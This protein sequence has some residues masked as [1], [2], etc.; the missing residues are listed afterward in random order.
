M[1]FYLLFPCVIHYTHIPRIIS[2][3]IFRYHAKTL[4]LLGLNCAVVLGIR[5]LGDHLNFDQV[6]H[7]LQHIPI[8]A[9][10]LFDAVTLYANAVHQIIHNDMVVAA[11]A[12]NMSDKLLWPTEEKVSELL[13]NGTSIINLI[14]NHTYQSA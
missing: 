9:A 2:S 13:L 1:W 12:F 6:T 11:K 5:L 10:Y 14:R 3:Q 4:L 8:Y 7:Y